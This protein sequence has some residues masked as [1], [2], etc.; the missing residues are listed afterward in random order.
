[1]G[2]DGKSPLRF[3]RDC[4]PEERIEAFFRL[5]GDG[6]AFDLAARSDEVGSTGTEMRRFRQREPE[7]DR[8]VTDTMAEGK[9]AYQDRLRSQARARATDRANPSDRMLEVE[10]GTHVGEYGHLRRDRVQVDG[11]IRHELAISFDPAALDALPIEQRRSLREIL[12]KLDG[13]VVVDG[14]ARPARE[15]PAA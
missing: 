12:A 7:F 8:R 2:A 14:K 10:L 11:K 4:Y 15:L 1:M 9:L 6:I 13:D 5:L 3:A